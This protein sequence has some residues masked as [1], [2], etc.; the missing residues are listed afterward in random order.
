MTQVGDAVVGKDEVQ[1]FRYEFK[2]LAT[3][4]SFDVIGGDD[5]IRDLHLHVVER[6]QIVSRSWN[7]CSLTIYNEA[8]QAIPFSGR[9]EIPQGDFVGLPDRSQ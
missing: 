8:S 4:I 7:A 1:E 6:P 9:V 2:N 3:D 5:R